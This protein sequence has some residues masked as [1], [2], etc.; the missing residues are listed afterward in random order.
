[1]SFDIWTEFHSN[2]CP[3]SHSRV[4]YSRLGRV[5]DN[6]NVGSRCDSQRV[7]GKTPGLRTLKPQSNHWTWK[8]PRQKIW[9]SIEFYYRIYREMWDWYLL[10]RRQN[11][12]GIISFIAWFKQ[13]EILWKMSYSLYSGWQYWGPLLNELLQCVQG[14]F[15]NVETCQQ[16]WPQAHTSWHGLFCSGER[17]RTMS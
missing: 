8:E 7:E 15:H 4:C 13:C 6:V 11:Y 10:S 3:P 17:G 16:G 5:L 1:M 12:Y 9:T 2:R 14:R